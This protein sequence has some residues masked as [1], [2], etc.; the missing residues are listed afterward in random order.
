V[1]GEPLIADLSGVLLVNMSLDQLPP[2]TYYIK[3]SSVDCTVDMILKECPQL[4]QLCHQVPA[5]LTIGSGYRSSISPRIEF[6]T[7]HVLIL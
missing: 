6:S 4:D 7:G 1:N 3:S 5:Q 2:N